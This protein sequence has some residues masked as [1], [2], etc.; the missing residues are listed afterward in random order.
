MRQ[1]EKSTPVDA[2]RMLIPVES[3][4]QIASSRCS[5]SSSSRHINCYKKHTCHPDPTSSNLCIS[6]HP[7]HTYSRVSTPLTR[8]IVPMPLPFHNE[9]HCTTSRLSIVAAVV[10]A[11]DVFAAAAAVVVVVHI[12]VAGHN[13]HWI[14]QTSDQTRIPA[15]H[16]HHIHRTPHLHPDHHIPLVLLYHCTPLD[17]TH[18]HSTTSH[19]QL[20]VVVEQKGTDDLVQHRTFPFQRE[21]DCPQQHP[22]SL[23]HHTLS[24]L[25]NSAIVSIHRPHHPRPQEQDLSLGVSRQFA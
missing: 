9:V 25:L 15:A 24:P 6:H 1:E 4:L 8:F 5:C 18:S 14:H 3:S 12:A 20:E 13:P 7:L 21:E 22:C 10:V 2:L 19:R 23:H 11:M 17:P 16:S